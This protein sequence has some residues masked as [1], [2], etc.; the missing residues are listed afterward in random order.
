VLLAAGTVLVY[1]GLI[2]L[3]AAAAR[4]VLGVQ[5][6]AALTGVGGLLIVAIGLSLCEIGKLRPGNLLPALALAVVVAAV[7]GAHGYTIP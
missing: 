5:A 2:A 6:L 4:Q 1:E 3:L 7:A